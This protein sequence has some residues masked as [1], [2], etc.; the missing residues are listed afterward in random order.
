[1]INRRTLLFGTAGL[2][3]GG[4][5]TSCSRAAE[6]ALKL[7]LLEGSVPAEVL[8]R[9]RQQTDEPVSFQALT[10]IRSIFQQ[11]QRWQEKPEPS[12]FSIERF[13][14]WVD[15]EAAAKP[16]DLVSLGDYWLSSAIA[17]NLI[18]PLN[19][20]SESIDKL[21]DSW[22]Q[23]VRRDAEGQVPTGANPNNASL[24]AAPYKVQTLVIVY[25]KN[26]FPKATADSPPFQS[27]NDLLQPQLAQ[28]IALPNHPRIVIG[29]LQKIQS[30]SF[31]P[32]LETSSSD[33]TNQLTEQLVEPFAQLNRQVKTYDSQ[34]PLKA[35]INGD[36]KAIVS[37]SG[38]VVAALR[39]YQDLR[40]VVPQE[41]SLLSADM[42][43]QPRGVEM[44]EAAQ[45]WIDFC[46]QAGPATQMSVA[47]RGLSPIF[48]KADA[49]LPE[50]LS[51]GI[52]PVEVMRKS[53]PLLPIP[54]TLQA[55]YLELWDKLRT[56]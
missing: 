9:F 30:G 5:L 50:V 22:Q 24:W 33:M 40:V 43:V 2:V 56:A 6:D 39:R 18:S 46:W 14:P 41:G 47:G 29:L 51:E 36:V 25:R 13:L 8:K 34:N 15:A 27:W 21:P 10:Q 4:S 52:L 37:W 12:A 42:W 1:M 54:D 3:V 38:D 20:P 32:V 19:I 55:T 45:R 23:F 31:N 28:N 48:L 7:T 16:D 35:L 26:L 49:S 11:L 53:E 44:S 17:Q